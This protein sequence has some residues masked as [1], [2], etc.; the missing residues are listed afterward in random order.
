MTRAYSLRAHPL[1]TTEFK[2]EDDVVTSSS[3]HVVDCDLS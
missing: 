2:G 3:E 1:T